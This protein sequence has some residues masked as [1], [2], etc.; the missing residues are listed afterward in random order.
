MMN[1]AII[2][3]PA[4]TAM[5]SGR[6]KTEGWTLRYTPESA[7]FVEPLMGWVGSQDTI[8][9][10][11]LSFDTKEEAIAYAEK[12]KIEYVL[13]EPESRKINPKNYAANFAPTRKIA[14][15]FSQS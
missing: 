3:Q 15:T 8:R 5:Q 14:H 12:N 7:Q 6:A 2:F 4:K 9:Q 1:T 11:K 10:L 13:K